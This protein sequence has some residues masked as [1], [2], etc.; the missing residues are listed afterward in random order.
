MFAQLLKG[1]TLQSQKM[2]S[3]ESQIT[4]N[5][6]QLKDEMKDK[7][8]K[9]NISI[10]ELKAQMQ[11]RDARMD[12]LEAKMQGDRTPTGR[13]SSPLPHRAEQLEVDH[14]K[15]VVGGWNTPQR[16]VVIEQRLRE[17]A[18]M[19]NIIPADLYATK[20]GKVGFILFAQ[21]KDLFTFICKMKELKPF[22][23]LE[24]DPGPLW[25][26]KS[27]P[28][29]ERDRTKPIRSL[30]RAFY[31]WFETHPP[32]TVPNDFMIDY[33][34]AEIVFGNDPIAWIKKNDR[35]DIIAVDDVKFKLHLPDLPIEH[36]KSTA[37]L[38]LSGR[39]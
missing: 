28:Q 2:V 16:K 22:T 1:Q 23:D 3:M 21:T 29:A 20:R 37:E 39:E 14:D 8:T 36:I 13:Q 30:G 32:N 12:E 38:Y 5:I 27:I 31:Q 17:L 6:T 35:H 10:N 26:K 34:R 24:D 4:S 19:A 11:E 18:D 7:D 9:V 15:V 25:I 33:V